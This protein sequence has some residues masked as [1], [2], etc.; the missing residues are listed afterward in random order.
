MFHKKSL[1]NML[2]LAFLNDGFGHGVDSGLVLETEVHS[3][4][5]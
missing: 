5:V 1:C 2:R 3:G 4:D